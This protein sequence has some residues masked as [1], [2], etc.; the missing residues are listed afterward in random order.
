MR[1]VLLFVHDVTFWGSLTAFFIVAI[2][3]WLRHPSLRLIRLVLHGATATLVVSMIARWVLAGHPPV[4]GTFE[5]ALAAAFAMAVVLIVELRRTSTREAPPGVYAGLLS[6][7][8]PLTL[9]YGV[10]FP[11]TPYPLTISER[12]LFID[13]HVL[14]AWVAYAVLVAASLDSIA[15]LF[16]GD[17]RG[18]VEDCV[19]RVVR[20]AGTGFAVFTAMCAVGSVYSYVLFADFWRWEIVGT[21]AVVAWMGYGA[22]LHMRLGFGWKDRRLLMAM[23]AMLPIVLFVFWSWSLFSGTYHHFDLNALIAR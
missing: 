5:N 20:S 1:T 17:D 11:R 15:S 3:A 7:F 4:F 14:L 22:V 9:A 2:L 6:I 16:G 10:F 12:S 13:V 8:P 23:A 18:P 19:D 21:S